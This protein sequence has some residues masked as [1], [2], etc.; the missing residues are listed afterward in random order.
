MEQLTSIDAL[1][2]LRPLDIQKHH[3]SDETSI[4][5][6]IYKETSVLEDIVLTIRGKLAYI[7]IVVIEPDRKRDILYISRDKIHVCFKYEST[8]DK[9]DVY[10]ISHKLLKLLQENTDDGGDLKIMITGEQCDIQCL[11]SQK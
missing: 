4:T 2:I 5:Y 11:V 1:L 10:R 3:N 9:V 6:I 7:Q 8:H